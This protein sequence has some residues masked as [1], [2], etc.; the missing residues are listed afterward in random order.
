MRNRISGATLAALTLVLASCSDHAATTRP[1]AF[2]IG[3]P[4]FSALPALPP[5]RVS[6]IHYDNTGTDAGE[7]MEI[8][9]P[10]GTDLTGWSLVLYNGNGGDSYSTTTLT[11]S[12]PAT[13]GTRGVVVVSYPVN[14]IQNGDPDGFALVNGSSVVE[15]LSYEGT[16][17]ATNG[18]ASGTLSSDIGVREAGTE[19]QGLSL[20]R[21]D[22]GSW[23]GP[24]ASSF[25]ACNTVSAI[26]RP[27]IT[28][29]GRNAITDPALPVGFEAQIF[30]TEKASS[31]EVATTFTWSSDRAPARR[32]RRGSA[33]RRQSPFAH[34]EAAGGGAAAG[35]RQHP[36]SRGPA[37]ERDQRAGRDDA[38]GTA[39]AR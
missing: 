20:Q 29:S 24:A 12:I 9:G 33:R 35:A 14:G 25:G 10:A 37:G 27:T 30:A 3:G 34:G 7:A 1:P 19:P 22:D 13:C 28:F 8:E 26:P 18:P 38:V 4:R 5:V 6:E 39:A 15:F 16:F 2:G 23:T 32:G 17:T 21:A 31:T 11:G 36:A